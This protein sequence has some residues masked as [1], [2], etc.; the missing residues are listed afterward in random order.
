MTISA[1]E[2]SAR[3]VVRGRSGAWLLALAVLA[4]VA[5][6]IA[7]ERVSPIFASD[8]FQSLSIARSLVEGRGFSS[9]GAEHPDASR[10]VLFPLAVGTIDAV[11]RSPELA[12]RIVVLLCGALIVV[13]MFCFARSAFG[14]GAALA[15]L[16]LGAVSC[17]V[18]AS[19]RLLSTSMFVLLAMSSV[20]ACWS[21]AQRR[22]LGRWIVVGAMMG[23]AALSRPEGLALPPALAAWALC[24]VWWRGGRG[25]DSRSRAL[26]SAGTALLVFAVVYAPYVVWVSSRLGRLA[27]APGID[28]IRAERAVSDHLQLR[29]MASDVPWTSRA[30][31]M[32]TQDHKSFYLETFFLTGE[33]PEPD[34]DVV[35]P[36]EGE[37]PAVTANRGAPAW[38]LVV[39]RRWNIVRGN[40]L[41]VPWKAHWAHFLPPVIVALGVAGMTSACL[42]HRGRQALLL[43]VIAGIAS[44]APFV[45]HI[46]D[47]FFC[48]PFTIMAALAAAGWAFL[49][50]LLR[51]SVAPGHA[52]WLIVT[53][54]LAL[55]GWIAWEGGAHEGDRPEALARAALLRSHAAS[56]GA[57]LAP[58]PILGIDPH[59]PYWAA[60]PYRPI[61]FG[62]SNGILDFARTVGAVAIVVE[63]NRD[64]E[65]RPDLAWLMRDE[66]PPQL[67]VF[68]V[69]PHPEGGELR[70][71][72]FDASPRTP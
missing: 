53:V 33:F 2:W 71:L 50:R 22:G 47:R 41:R 32:L 23:L 17:V 57:T 59:F 70:V 65:E 69:V 49:D 58:G 20:A 9:G 62:T 37:N 12:A 26:A 39:R 29:E 46:E 10:S 60:R 6:R 61:P 25:R 4:G 67:Q 38:R 15:A 11:V 18:G 7:V 66:L 34:A 1:S 44:L 51:R 28:Y 5:S 36:A 35:P 30:R 68:E 3:R 13:P 45:N 21:A 63:G 43:L 27:L 19:A 31:F 56:A 16:P 64:L 72:A 55:F 24:V 54:H 52:R 42:R 14:P 8:T 48:L 40:L